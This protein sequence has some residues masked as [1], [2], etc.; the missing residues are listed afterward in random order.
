MEL[1]GPI[2]Q[3]AQPGDFVF[4]L[5]VHLPRIPPGQVH[6]LR[7]AVGLGK[8]GGDRE[9]MPSGQKRGQ[10]AR[11]SGD[12]GVFENPHPAEA[13]INQKNFEGARARIHHPES[14][15]W[16]QGDPKNCRDHGVPVHGHLLVGGRSRGHGSSG[17]SS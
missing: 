13:M 8:H 3:S 1:N 2:A 11:G 10:V 6:H 16:K 15:G 17:V 12:F 14:S 9:I 5:S 7:Q 4:N